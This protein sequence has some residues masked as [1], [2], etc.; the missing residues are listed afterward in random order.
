MSQIFVC[1]SQKASAAWVLE[2]D[3][4]GCFD[5]INHDWLV[6]HV[7]MN[8][9]I[10][11]KWLKAGVVHKGQLTPTDEGTPQGGIISPT[12]ANV[13]LNGLE[14]DLL[15]HLRATVGKKNADKL[16]VNVI[17][18]ADDFVV[19]GISKE[20][21]D[22]QVRPWIEAFLALRGL[23]LSPEKTRVT[24]IDD[25][26]DFL[27]WNFRKYRGT[28]LIKPSRKN[29]KAFYDKVAKVIKSHLMVKQAVLID[30]LN[31]ILRGWAQYHQPVVAKEVFGKL[32]SLIHWRLTR[33][34]RRRHP[35]KSPTWCFQRYW[36][37]LEGRSE[38]AAARHT[39]EGTWQP[40]RLNLLADTVITRHRKIK[41]DYNPFD[42][43]WELYGEELRAKRML[44]SIS[45]RKELTN[46]Y[47]SQSG[48]CALC[49]T[50]ITR[51]TGWH[52]HHIVRKVDGGADLLSNRVLLHPV[53]HA[54]LHAK[55]LTVVKP[56]PQG[57]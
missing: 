1:M 45:Y 51:E 11:K 27:G 47:K 43:E 24:H 16:K 3:I 50:A 57:A 49:G 12:L 56:A 33:W 2:A 23:R 22:T 52:D 5:N 17:R 53:C 26:F 21:L 39:D 48:S 20:V 38:F 34:T 55:G 25:G 30:K 44:K 36:K 8:K 46:L 7:R 10:L 6:S 41:G 54:K 4:Q 40:A 32:D 14:S 42:P 35:K 9:T 31:P 18:Y 29:A 19:T 37:H 28:M 13:T 15:A